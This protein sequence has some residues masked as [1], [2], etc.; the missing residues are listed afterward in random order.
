MIPRISPLSC[1]LV[2]PLQMPTMFR[3]LRRPPE[4]LI[5]CAVV[6]LWAAVLVAASNSHS[7]PP[8]QFLGVGAFYYVWYGTPETDGAYMHWNHSILPHWNA[9]VQ[10]QHAG[11]LIFILKQALPHQKTSWHRK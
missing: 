7:H 8:A 6:A 1:G 5:P 2:V 9:H 11:D 4:V 3:E 10:A